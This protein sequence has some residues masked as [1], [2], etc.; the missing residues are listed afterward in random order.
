MRLN[1]HLADVALIARYDLVRRIR[2][3]SALFTA[4]IGPLSLAVVFSLLIGGADGELSLEIAIA[5]EDGSATSTAIVVGLTSAAEGSTDAADGSM[6][7]DDGSIGFVAV[8]DRD[9]AIADVG[10]GVVDAAIVIP[11]GYGEAVATG[12]A[13]A[14]EILRDPGSPIAAEV[15]RAVAGS[16]AGDIGRTT[17]AT[18]AAL[19]ARPDLDPAVVAAAAR[20]APAAFAPIDEPMGEGEVS[21]GAYYGASMAILFLFFTIG[22]AARSIVVERT[23]G[24]LDRILATPTRLG[25][26]IAGKTLS[27]CVLGFAGFVTTWLITTWGFGASWGSPGAVVA[28]VATTVAAVGGVAIFVAALARTEQQ[29][30]TYTSAVAFTLALLGGNF[31][32]P[33]SAPPVMRTLSLATPNGWALEAFTSVSV[34]GASAADVAPAIGILLLFA[35]AFGAVGFALLGRR[36]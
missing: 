21:V 25:A 6:E 28:L 3:R 18:G 11:P 4:F 2:N 15:A 14:L 31:V 27:V 30:D 7:P 36:G 19:V 17:L 29:A 9:R 32:G 5:D 16:I 33:G 23:T 34:D 10:G 13:T 20:D 26:V 1:A 12:R 8:A 22:F 24:T 35:V